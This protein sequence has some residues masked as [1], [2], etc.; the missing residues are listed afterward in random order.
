MKRGKLGKP[1]FLR[2]GKKNREKK[3]C[4]KKNLVFNKKPL[5]FRVGR[6][7]GI[8]ITLYLLVFNVDFL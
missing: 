4:E 2:V 5:F 8:Y 6:A 1:G 7:D 3:G